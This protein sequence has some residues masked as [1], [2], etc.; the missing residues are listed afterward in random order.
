MCILSSGQKRLQHLPHP[1]KR[2]TS[3]T[4]HFFG[5]ANV[6]PRKKIFHPPCIHSDRIQLWKASFTLFHMISLWSLDS[7]LWIFGRMIP[8]N[9]IQTWRNHSLQIACSQLANPMECLDLQKSFRLED[10]PPIFF[11][12]YTPRMFSNSPLKNEVLKLLLFWDGKLSG[13]KLNFQGVPLMLLKDSHWYCLIL[14]F[15]S[16]ILFDK[17]VRNMAEW[18]FWDFC[19][20]SG[21]DSTIQTIPHDLDVEGKN[22]FNKRNWPPTLA[23]LNIFTPSRFPEWCFRNHRYWCRIYHL[24]NSSKRPKNTKPFK[25]KGFSWP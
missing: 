19:A 10:A 6:I 23:P 3:K 16:L 25:V 9:V 18:D 12:E 15:D 13:T 22:N 5:A 17:S 20:I 11:W 1:K 21:A 7:N 24:R 2:R 8:W 14:W 4:Y